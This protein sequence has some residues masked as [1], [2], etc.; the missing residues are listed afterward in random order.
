[1][2]ALLAIARLTLKAAFRFRLVPILGLVLVGGVLLLPA[3]IKDDQTAVGMTQIV[4]S[5]TLG[6]TT[7]VLGLT[8]LWLACGTLARDIEEGQIQVVVAKP[9]ARWRIWLGKWLGIM[10]LNALLLGLAAGIVYVQMQWRARKLPENQQEVLRNEVFTA[11]G[12]FHEK[13]PEIEPE[14]ERV[15]QER[16]KER[17]V[18]GADREEVRNIIRERLKARLQVVPPGWTRTWRVDMSRVRDRVRDQYLFLRVKFFAAEESASATYAGI[19]DMGPP[20]SPHRQREVRNQ[21]A[22]TFHEFPVF[23]NLLDD[24]GILT[25]QF[26]NQTETAL[27]FPLEDGLEVLYHE[28]GFALNYCRGIVIVF[29]WLAL[30][31]AIGLAAASFLS[32]PVAA[33]VSLGLLV[34]VFSTG[35]MSTIIDQGTI[36]AV[37]HETGYVA[38]PNVFDQ[39]TVGAF[40][41]LLGAVNLV[42]DFS[43]ID[44]LSRGRSITWWQL[45]RA[46][47]Q[48]VFLAGGLFAGMGIWIFERREL[49][50]AQGKT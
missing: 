44:S 49:A 17:P 11:R 31:A 36:L 32:F 35:T 12:S 8:T 13:T 39:V 33:F 29:C 24:N 14:V 34:V 45:C 18:A 26:L 25:I 3:V 1:M 46:V 2:Q 48:I 21:S 5:Y 23:P 16:M 15:F 41:V 37:D 10:A 30:L 42:R 20:E 38:Q 19:W 7:A 50:T 22:E 40:K 43:P 9:V 47:G 28:G 4:L 27:V 6:L